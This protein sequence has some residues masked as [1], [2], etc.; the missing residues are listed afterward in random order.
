[1]C[2]RALASQPTKGEFIDPSLLFK[3]EAIARAAQPEALTPLRGLLSA[4]ELEEL[5]A[6]RSAAASWAP[7]PPGRCARSRSASSP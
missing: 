4:F 7:P 3:I 2:V 5:R 6:K 1:M